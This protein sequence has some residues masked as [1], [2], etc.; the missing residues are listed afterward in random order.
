MT[1]LPFSRPTIG[2]EELQAIREVLETG[3]ITTGP[4]SLALEQALADYIGGDVQVRVFNSATS[5]LEASLLAAGI[6]PGD[7][8]I[9]PAISFV[10][11]ANVVLRAG[12]RPVFVE[13]DLHS[14]NL[15]AAAVAAAWTP[16]TR[17]VI[18]VH[19]AGLAVDM[20]PL[21]AL[22]KKHQLLLLEDAAQAIGTEYQGRK[23]GASGNPVSFSFHPN[24]NM[25]TIEGGAVASTDADFM[26]RLERLRFHGI[27]RDA[28]GNID[29]T[30]WGGK[31]NL[32]DVNAAVG[33][34]QLMRLDRFNQRRRELAQR[35]F[36]LL[37]VN[38]TLVLPAD[39]AGHSWH[40]FCV[41]IDH[42]A[43]GKTRAEIMSHFSEHGITVGTHYPAMHLFSLYRQ[44]GYSEGDFPVAEKIGAQTLT[45]PLFPAMTE[46]DVD[47]VCATVT[48]IVSGQI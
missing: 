7:E 14:R 4:K 45:L 44:F 35:Y 37:P 47:H 34:V 11:T 17:A 36:Q 31:M 25:T 13:V 21:Y 16:A 39:D 42:V 10:A 3:W 1:T 18:P 27:E 43:L 46:A 9:V 19:F 8:V 41:C 26:K 24:K 22:A 12:A 28:D 15:D 38:E 32:P 33:M 48:A 20:E 5:A 6:G 2:E 23:I 30:A 29:V 40:M